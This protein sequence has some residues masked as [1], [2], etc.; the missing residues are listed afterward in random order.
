[1]RTDPYIKE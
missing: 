1:M